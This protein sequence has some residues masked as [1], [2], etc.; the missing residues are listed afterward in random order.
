MQRA[1]N[2]G[3]GGFTLVELLVVIAII[4]ILIGMLLPA[5]QA[6]REAARR[7]S[8][9]NQMRQM[10]LGMLY[11]E[12]AH[13]HFPAGMTSRTITQNIID[14]GMVDEEVF[15][16]HGLN[17]SCII[18]PFMEQNSMSELIKADSNNFTFPRWWVGPQGDL[19]QV[20][21]PIF[22]CPSDVMGEINTVRANDHGKSNYVGIL[23]PRLGADLG[24]ISNFDQ[25]TLD[26]SGSTG[27]AADRAE[28]DFPG[29]LYFNSEVSMGQISDGTSNTFVVSERDGAPLRNTEWTR[30][31]AT[32]C[33]ANRSEWLN[34]CLAPTSIEPNQTINASVFTSRNDQW[35]A[36]TSQHTGGANF[37]RSD[38]SVEFVSETIDGLVYQGMG[39]KSGG[40]VETFNN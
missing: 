36:I 4:G 28:L 24:S 37:G 10:T 35:T 16:N 3:K 11:Y 29:V 13:Q 6:V 25:F 27:S 26:R 30:A 39:T 23:G 7:M 40:E 1:I 31:A 33:G 34:Q 12:S 15:K 18:L 9:G 38:G 8:C 32:W 14:A 17:W 20:V 22:L 21:L 2:K 5:V 19:A